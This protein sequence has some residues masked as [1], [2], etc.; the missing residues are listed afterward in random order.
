M[1]PAMTI[2]H[3]DIIGFGGSLLFITA[4]LY[5]NAVK[6]MDK[7]LFNALN[8]VGAMLLLYSLWVHPNVAAAFLEISWACIALF[9]LVSAVRTRRKA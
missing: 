3:A 7:L 8:L 9:G 1:I 2:D 5:A 6:D 4:F